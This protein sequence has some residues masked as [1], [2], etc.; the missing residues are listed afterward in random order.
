MVEVGVDRPARYTT[1]SAYTHPFQLPGR[2]ELEDPCSHTRSSRAAS[3]TVNRLPPV[4]G[5]LR[6][7]STWAMACRSATSSDE[8]AAS[9]RRSSASADVECSAVAISWRT[10]AM[11]VAR[12]LRCGRDD[13][14]RTWA[15]RRSAAELRVSAR[16]SASRRVNPVATAWLLPAPG[17][18]GR[19]PTATL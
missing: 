19:P 16:L 5:A 1:R 4:G 11:G 6:T 9:A 14:S 18:L 10:V 2:E 13:R 7:A 15:V 17:R 12:C 8:S 3:S